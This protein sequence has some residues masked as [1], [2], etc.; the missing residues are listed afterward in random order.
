MTAYSTLSSDRNVGFD[1][2]RIPWTA[3]N[4]YS[5]RY[6]LDDYE[7]DI[8][9]DLICAMDTEYLDFRS[10]KHKNKEPVAKKPREVDARR[11]R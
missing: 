8:L 2:G 6:G 10:R 4:D 11:V 3:V 7:L 5:L 1:E 9:W